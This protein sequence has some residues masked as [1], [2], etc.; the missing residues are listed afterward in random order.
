MATLICLL[1]IS[2]LL[3]LWLGSKR[4][5]KIDF[6][7]H[8]DNPFSRFR[9]PIKYLQYKRKYEQLESRID[10]CHAVLDR[11]KGNSVT[12]KSGLGRELRTEAYSMMYRSVLEIEILEG[13]IRGKSSHK[14]QQSKASPKNTPKVEE[15]DDDE[16]PGE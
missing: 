11:I 9:S 2:A 13:T 1:S 7:T 8:I 16:I 15:F 5:I 3:V 14:F 12:S 10:G 4:S 6:D